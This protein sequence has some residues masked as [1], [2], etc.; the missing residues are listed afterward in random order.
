M[1]L[2]VVRPYGIGVQLCSCRSTG[3]LKTVACMSA[4]LSPT[5]YNYSHYE[6]ESPILVV[7]VRKLHKYLYDRPFEIYTDSTQKNKVLNSKAYPILPTMRWVLFLSGYSNKIHYFKQVQIADR[8]SRLP[9]PEETGDSNQ[10]QVCVSN[11]YESS[12]ALKTFRKETKKTLSQSKYTNGYQQIGLKHYL[13]TSKIASIELIL[14]KRSIH[15]AKRM[16]I[17]RLQTSNST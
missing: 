11:L 1:L 9:T 13:N 8:L 17:M 4:I 6:K 3:N 14:G 10:S 2:F 15:Y 12:P 5:E 16:L 7:A